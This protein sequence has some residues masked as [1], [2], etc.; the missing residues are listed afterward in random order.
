MGFSYVAIYI[1]E[2]CGLV[3]GNPY[4]ILV[5]IIE[6]INIKVN[7]TFRYDFSSVVLGEPCS[8]LAI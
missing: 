6:I 3:L 1:K 4:L 8:L 5:E 7:M 2:F